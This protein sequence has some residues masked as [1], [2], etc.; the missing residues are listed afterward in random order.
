M[1]VGSGGGGGGRGGDAWCEVEGRG[2]REGWVYR[3][4]VGA[5]GEGR[6]GLWA[7]VAHCGRKVMLR[8]LHLHRLHG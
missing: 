4:A 7:C 3:G 1:W 8:L 5:E 6:G 2:C